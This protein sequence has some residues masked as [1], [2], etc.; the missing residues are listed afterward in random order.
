MN[1]KINGEKYS[2]EDI[3][4]WESEQFIEFA[5]EHGRDRTKALRRYINEWAVVLNDNIVFGGE[6]EKAA[7]LYNEL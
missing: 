5:S 7:K 2:S 6:F 1:Y 3:K 4:Q